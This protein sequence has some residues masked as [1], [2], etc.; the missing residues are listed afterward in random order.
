[1]AASSRL[2][3]ALQASLGIPP[4]PSGLK[5]DFSRWTVVE[6]KW[7]RGHRENIPPQERVGRR[8]DTS[9]SVVTAG[10]RQKPT[11]SGPTGRCRA[12]RS[13]IHRAR[14]FQLYR[15]EVPETG[16]MVRVNTPRATNPAGKGVPPRLAAVKEVARISKG[17]Q[18]IMA[19]TKP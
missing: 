8:W 3:T 13:F 6:G 18:N 10:K 2:R 14:A 11:G 16:A 19:A 5:R 17:L 4:G 15:R 7:P 9:A 1:M 12:P